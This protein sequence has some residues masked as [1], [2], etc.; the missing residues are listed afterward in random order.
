[1]DKTQ[2]QAVLIAKARGIT[3]SIEKM[4][5]TQRKAIPTGMYGENYNRLRE[6]VASFLRHN[7]QGQ[8]ENLLPP[9]VDFFSNSSNRQFCHQSYGEIH[10]FCEEI[11]QILSEL[12]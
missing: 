11:A 6:N 2:E 10:T 5:E 3:N 12:K 7:Y 9:N 4:V 8:G 1:M